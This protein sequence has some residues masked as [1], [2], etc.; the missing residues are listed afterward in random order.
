DAGGGLDFEDLAGLKTKQPLLALALTVFMLSLAGIPGTAG[1]IGKYGV[2][3]AAVDAAQTTGD[4]SFMLLAV[5]GI[6]NSLVGLYYY[7]RV[8]IQLY[9]RDLP[10][11][12]AT[13]V[14]AARTPALRF[15][16]VL[17]LVATLWLGFGF[18]VMH[19]GVEPA[20]RMVK[21]ALESLN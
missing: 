17:A 3:A 2:F 21:T 1:F 5:L 4:E 12:R 7:L 11:A 13:E 19:F 6:L 16:V 9:A 20:M 15:V 14:M 10:E 18:E 8:P